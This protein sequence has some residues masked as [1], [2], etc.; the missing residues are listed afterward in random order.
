MALLPPPPPRGEP[1]APPRPSRWRKVL[2]IG[3]AGVLVLILAAAVIVRQNWTRISHLYQRA[4]V[5][6]GTMFHLITTLQNTYGGQVN[7]LVRQVNGG[8]PFLSVRLTNPPFLEQLN[9]DAPEAKTKALEVA[10]TA[11]DALPPDSEYPRY[12]VIL[13]RSRGSGVTVAKSWVFRFEAGDLP[14]RGAR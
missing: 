10:A 6:V 8:P 13:E 4:G 5:V 12:E 1:V 3:C 9:P 7:V 11:R 14:P 2:A